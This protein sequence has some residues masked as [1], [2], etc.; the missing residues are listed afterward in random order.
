MRKPIIAG[1]WKMN[2][3]VGEAKAFVEEVKGAIPSSDKVD[4]VV[5]SPALFLEGLVQKAE[6][7]ELRIGAQNM[8]F[9]ESGAFTGEISPVALSDMKVD[10]V[11]LGHSERRDMFAE[12]DELV[13]KKTHAA[14]AHGLTPIVCVG[15]TLEE[16]EANQTYDVVKT[17]VEKGL[18]GLTDEQV[19]VT[20]IA[21]EPVWAIGTGKSSSAEDANDV[22]SYIRKV[23]TEKFSQEAADAVR[24]QYGGS[25]K[26]ANIAEYMAQS[27]IDGALVGGAS[28]DP[29]S[30]LQLLEAVK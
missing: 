28:L 20:V 9:E 19:K 21:Y 14:F 10:Y 11:I 17:Q 15:E 1:N 7:T 3:T 27:D 4:S 25:V 30:F 13:N 8:H 16:R 12:T 26:P 5:C 22:C 6:G 24:I 2:K 29:Q 18:E 23:V